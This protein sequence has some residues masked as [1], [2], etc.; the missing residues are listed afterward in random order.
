MSI[1]PFKGRCWTCGHDHDADRDLSSGFGSV[2]DGIT[3]DTPGA[4]LSQT[5]GSETQ[6]DLTAA[7]ESQAMTINDVME[8]AREHADASTFSGRCVARINLRKAL[9][10]LVAAEREAIAATFD[11]SP[12]AEMFR[13]DIA[14]EIRNP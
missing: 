7:S 4:C 14:H 13:Q 1:G 5:G 11:S 8:I 9:A 10:A 6:A 12:N 3:T 2:L